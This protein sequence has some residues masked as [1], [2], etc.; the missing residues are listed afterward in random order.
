MLSKLQPICVWSFN[1]CQNELFEMIEL[2]QDYPDYN[3][4]SKISMD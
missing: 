3:F 4:Q 1:L 2:I